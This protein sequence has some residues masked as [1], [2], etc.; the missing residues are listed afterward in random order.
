M[1]NFWILAL[2]SSVLL[3]SF[4]CQ[5]EDLDSS[6]E[7]DPNAFEFKV[8][9]NGMISSPKWLAIKVDSV[10]HAYKDVFYPEV[11]KISVNGDFYIRVGENPLSSTMVGLFYQKDGKRIYPA[12]PRW[13]E[14]LQSDD[15][16]LLWYKKP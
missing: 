3:I 10:A 2:L 1:K 14:I 8:G 5:K 6:S 13:I 16:E 15:K 7:S 4:S 11:L 12:D 9:K